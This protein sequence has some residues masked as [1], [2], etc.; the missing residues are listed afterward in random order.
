MK[1]RHE[2]G[3]EIIMRVGAVATQ[4]VHVPTNQ[5]H[6]SSEVLHLSKV[7]GLSTGRL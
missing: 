5:N 3:Y 2:D 6:E 7:Q 4:T 1:L